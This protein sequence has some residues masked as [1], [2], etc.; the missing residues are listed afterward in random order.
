L[1]NS[2]NDE[3]YKILNGFVLGLFVCIAVEDCCIMSWSFLIV[4]ISDF[5]C[6]I[7]ASNKPDKEVDKEGENIS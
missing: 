6:T 3:K 1:H 5:L 7:E 4:D 2:S